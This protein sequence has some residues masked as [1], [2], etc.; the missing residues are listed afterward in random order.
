MAIT[1]ETSIS[2]GLAI[3]LGLVALSIIASAWSIKADVNTMK[4]E[5]TV[6]RKA[7]DKNTEALEAASHTFVSKT[8]VL[9]LIENELLK[10][11]K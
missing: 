7:V 10:A 11:K 5:V 6:M 2:L 4:T 3:T 1:K 9:L 8:E